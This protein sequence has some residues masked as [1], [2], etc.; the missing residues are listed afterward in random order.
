MLLPALSPEDTRPAPTDPAGE[1]TQRR[2][3][4]SASGPRRSL[5]GPDAGQPF[6]EELLVIGVVEAGELG[7]ILHEVLFGDD[8]V[9]MSMPSRGQ[10]LRVH[11]RLPLGEDL[12][13][14][15]LL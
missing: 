6:D 15:V 4:P 13:F 2:T 8:P 10:L 9:V 14:A 11:A 12:S 5:L 7:R 1:R 3:F